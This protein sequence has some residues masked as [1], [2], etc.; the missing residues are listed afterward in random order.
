MK[1]TDF[2]QGQDVRLYWEH[3]KRFRVT[4]KGQGHGPVHI[5]VPVD[6]VTGELIP[7]NGE[8]PNRPRQVNSRAIEET[9][10]QF[11]SRNPNWVQEQKQQEEEKEAAERFVEQ[12]EGVVHETAALFEALG[13]ETEVQKTYGRVGQFEIRITNPTEHQEVLREMVARKWGVHG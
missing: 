2:K 11:I 6:P 7:D 1:A 3:N 4:H 10:D 9:W 12:I 13:F 8:Y 5:V